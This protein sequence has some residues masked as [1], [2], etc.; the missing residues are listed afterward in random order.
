MN[1]KS[2]ELENPFQ[3]AISRI[4]FSSRSNNL[5]IS[6]WDNTLRLY[7]VD[8]SV[9]RLEAPCEAGLLDCCFQGEMAA[10]SVGSDCRV[11]RYDLNSGIQNTIGDHDDLATCIEY[12]EATSQ[13]ITTGL[14]KIINFWDVRVSN[15]SVGYSKMVNAE[16]ESMS[17]SGLRL[18][19]ATG[20]T[21]NMYDLRN[22]EQPVQTNESSM[23]YQIACIRSSPN[24]QGYAVSSIEGHVSLKFFEP[25]DAHEIGGYVFRCYPKSKNWR[26]HQVAVNDIAFHPCYGTFVTGD[27]EGYAIIWDGRSTKR[28]FELPRYPN[29]V[30][31]MSYNQDGQILA[32]A[33]SYTYQEAN[34]V[35]EAPQIF[36]H[37]MD[38]NFVRPFSGGS[39]RQSMCFMP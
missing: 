27:N 25:S 18:L 39:S 12:S 9:L 23:D 14:D 17:L 32:I 8:A 38:E 24:F 4:R 19:V 2:L 28:L 33:S 26:Y 13:V 36:I 21:V 7:D 37:E 15:G 1:T 30:A 6:S 11:R 10:Y 22:L 29:S 20:T 16:V 3:D 5:L 35:E 34:E 31:S